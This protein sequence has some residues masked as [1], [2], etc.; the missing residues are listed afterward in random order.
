MSIY[1][2]PYTAQA[3]DQTTMNTEQVNR[4]GFSNLVR[5]TPGTRS[6]LYRVDCNLPARR[7]RR[8]ARGR[9]INLRSDKWGDLV[10]DEIPTGIYL[11]RSGTLKTLASHLTHQVNEVRMEVDY[12]MLIRMLTG[13]KNV[14]G[15]LLGDQY[16]Y[17]QC[18]RVPV[19]IQSWDEETRCVPVEYKGKRRYMV[20]STSVLFYASSD[21]LHEGPVIFVTADDVFYQGVPGSGEYPKLLSDSENVIRNRFG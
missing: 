19:V 10:E 21:T 11:A 3:P 7:S 5:T 1:L 16:L 4:R 17:R 9:G 8:S 2:P 13:L 20:P 15:T 18:Y 6:K 12:T 14:T